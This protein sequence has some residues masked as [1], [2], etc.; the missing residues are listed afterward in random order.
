MC[1][2]WFQTVLNNLHEMYVSSNRAI[3]N[4]LLFCSA[5]AQTFI[6]DVLKGNYGMNKYIGNTDMSCHKPKIVKVSL[7]AAFIVVEFYC[8][9]HFTWNK[10][11]LYWRVNCFLQEPDFFKMYILELNWKIVPCFLG[12]QVYASL[13]SLVFFIWY[14]FCLSSKGFCRFS[15]PESFDDEC[16][17]SSLA[18]STRAV[19]L[20]GLNLLRINYAS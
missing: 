7:K 16:C 18:S 19:G 13:L 20:E 6:I 2:C 12:G 17:F 5:A 15:T 8:F 9:D 4:W 11:K 3:D 10:D 14:F 1:S